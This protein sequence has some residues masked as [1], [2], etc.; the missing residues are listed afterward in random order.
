MDLE[1]SDIAISDMAKE[2]WN[3]SDYSS[4]HTSEKQFLS[5]FEAYDDEMEEIYKRMSTKPKKAEWDPENPP[6]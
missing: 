1:S 4:L 3:L 6:L 5:D 2:D